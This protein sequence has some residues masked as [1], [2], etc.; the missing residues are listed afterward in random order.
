MN[1][2]PF[3]LSF[4]YSRTIFLFTPTTF[5]SDNFPLNLA[6]AREL[7]SRNCTRYAKC[8]SG[9]SI[10]MPSGKSSFFTSLSVILSDNKIVV[11]LRSYFTVGGKVVKVGDFIKTK[12]I[13]VH[14]IRPNAYSYPSHY[15][16]PLKRRMLTLRKRCII[17]EF[18]VKDP[19]LEIDTCMNLQRDSGIFRSGFRRR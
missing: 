14:V 11:R 6:D 17:L 10:Q 1:I 9:Q 4:P 2:Y 13:Y 18:W 5:D 19:V 7:H 8:D 3:H 12:I 15:F 16:G